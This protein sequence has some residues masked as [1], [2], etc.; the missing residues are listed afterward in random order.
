MRM[1]A[2]SIPGSAEAIDFP[3]LWPVVCTTKPGEGGLHDPATRRHNGPRGE[4]CSVGG[5][6]PVTISSHATLRARVAATAMK[7]FAQAG[8]R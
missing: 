6:N 8:E 7:S 1:W 4:N 3:N 5:S 2:M